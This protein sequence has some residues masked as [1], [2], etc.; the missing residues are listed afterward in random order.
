MAKR[1]P[2]SPMTDSHKA[3][4]ATGRTEGKAVRDYLEALRANKPARGRKRTPESVTKRLAAI[5]AEIVSAD[6]VTELKL[7]QERINLQQELASLGTTVD[8]TALE[9]EFVKVAKSY[10]ERTGVS[11]AA[12]R[13]VGISPAVLKA[14]GITRGA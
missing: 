1:G 4:L 3:A 7:V 2:K 11:Y 14:A 9:A 12:W 13:A 5:E 10:A 6:A 8:L